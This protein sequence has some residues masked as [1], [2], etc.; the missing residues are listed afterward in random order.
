MINVLFICVKLLFSIF[1]VIL[2]LLL[3]LA[4]YHHLMIM[5]ERKDLTPNG[6]MIHVDGRKVHVYS[7]GNQ[8]NKPILV[9]LSG[10]ATVAP[11]YDFK[12]LYNKLTDQ[13]KIV[14]VEKNGYGY[15]DTSNVDRD[16]ASIVMEER[17]A[18]QNAGEY[19][20]YILVPHSMG[21]LEAVYWAQNYPDEVQG[22]IGLDMAVPEVYEKMDINRSLRTMKILKIV[23]FLGIQRIP[24][25]YPLNTEELDAVEKKQQ[26]LLLNNYS[27]N[28][29]FRLESEKVKA[30]AE[31]V[32]K[33][34]NIYV[35]LLLFVSSGSE[36]G[37]FWIPCEQK[38]AN[39]NHGKLILLP[40]G[41]YI[42]HYESKLLADEIKKFM[43]EF[44][45]MKE[46]II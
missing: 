46:G 21:G 40:C 24:R 36:I 35:P 33:G 6:S 25:V 12:S 34:G 37:D 19:G 18:L 44:I 32:K 14:V 1:L 28:H 22:L 29:N 38:F 27:M 41:H 11:V 42:H 7:Q 39:E 4:A 31:S 45:G 17:S 16:V 15:S 3:C 13:Y 5:K 26:K 30:N 20:P 8:S 2:F 9:F 43:M 23:C 10:S